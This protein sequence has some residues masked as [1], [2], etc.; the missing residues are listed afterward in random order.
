MYSKYDLF[1]NLSVLPISEVAVGLFLLLF[2]HGIFVSL[3]DSSGC[4][5]LKC[6]CGVSE[7]PRLHVSFF[8]MV[9][10]C[11][12]EDTENMINRGPSAMKFHNKLCL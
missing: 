4:L 7:N 2:I 1:K 3:C 12:S 11:F 5:P 8:K 10:F 9:F 6:V